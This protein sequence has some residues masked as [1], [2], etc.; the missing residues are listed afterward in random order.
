[1]AN[2]NLMRRSRTRGFNLI[3]VL[4]A[5]FILACMALMFAAVVPSSL[6]SIRTANYY[7][8]A[9][10]VAQRKLDQL[11]DPSIG[12]SNLTVATLTG[13]DAA[14][15]PGGRVIS[16]NVAPADACSWVDPAGVQSGVAPTS[17]TYAKKNYSLTGYFTTLDGL[18]RYK[19]NGTPACRE[20]LTKNAFPGDSDVEGK[21]VIEGWQGKTSSVSDSSLLKATVTITWRTS[22]QGKSSYTTSTLIPKSSIL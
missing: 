16:R 13:E 21:I 15:Y 10:I 9:A 4:V 17:S 6:R 7:N 18:R 11:M 8:L 22:G 5:V 20:L 12:Y 19:D 3:E 1:M 14:V 2:T